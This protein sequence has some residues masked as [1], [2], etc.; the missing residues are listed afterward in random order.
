MS[1]PEKTQHN[2]ASQNKD[3][4]AGLFA[5]TFFVACVSLYA[6]LLVGWLL[7]PMALYS[8]QAQP[9]DFSHAV[10]VE[11][12]GMECESCHLF[13]DD[14]SYQGV[15]TLDECIE[16]HE[17]V[18]GED[19]EEEKF[20][21]QYVEKEREVEWLIYSRQPD[22]VFFSHAAHVIKGQIDCAVCHGD[23]AESESLPVY[24]ENRIT[25]YSRA[26]WGKDISGVKKHFTRGGDRYY[27]AMKMDDCAACHAEAKNKDGGKDAC[28]VCHK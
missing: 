28:F 23:F 21:A 3:E 4:S 26:I 27:D 20:V 6:S 16:C 7:F 15:P 22:C 5:L 24:E 25:G 1:G 17:E 9:I 14:G 2:G 19:P 18:M 8:R 11:G 12:E 13:R 10:H